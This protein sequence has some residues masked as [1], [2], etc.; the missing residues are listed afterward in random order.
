MPFR[1]QSN[2][3]QLEKFTGLFQEDLLLYLG[4]RRRA[5]FATAAVPSTANAPQGLEGLRR[6]NLDEY[7]LKPNNVF[8]W[9]Q[10]QNNCAHE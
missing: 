5:P 4:V 3:G 9:G 6:S 2:V 8:L 7:Q 10:K 1:D